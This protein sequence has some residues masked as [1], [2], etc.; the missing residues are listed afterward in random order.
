MRR[1]SVRDFKVEAGKLRHGAGT[2]VRQTPCA[3]QHP[4]PCVLIRWARFRCLPPSGP[5]TQPHKHWSG[6]QA[7]PGATVTLSQLHPSHGMGTRP[8]LLP[9]PCHCTAL[10]QVQPGRIQAHLPSPPSEAA[11]LQQL[12]TG[13]VRARRTQLAPARAVPT[14]QGDTWEKPSIGTSTAAP[15]RIVS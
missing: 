11:S 6:E 14:H 13:T 15:G 2:Q 1:I 10:L 3:C 5:H 7:A 4:S 8:A 12:S 9:Q